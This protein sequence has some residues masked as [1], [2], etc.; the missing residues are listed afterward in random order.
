MIN[1]NLSDRNEFLQKSMVTLGEI[2]DLL[3]TLPD[4]DLETLPSQKTALVIVDMING[5]TREGALKS[6]RV[7]ALIPEIVE[8]SKKC[9]EYAIQKLA[10]ADRH[11]A[12]SP[13]F[14]AYPEHCMVNT[15]ESDVVDEIK[16]VGGYELIPKNSTN[17]FLEPVFQTWLVENAEV[18]HFIVVGDCTDICIQQYA[19][20]LKTWFNRQN[21]E[22]RIIVPI[23]SVNTYDFGMHNGDLVHVMA[24]FN[25]I[26]NGVEVVSKIKL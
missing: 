3:S 24:L 25:M 1:M 9:D 22:S 7:E 15:F 16:E 19:I 6:P 14:Q 21:K 20:T 4:L 23:S 5:F 11:T 12:T 13:E 10:F 26:G 17:G 18:D 2:A 8:L